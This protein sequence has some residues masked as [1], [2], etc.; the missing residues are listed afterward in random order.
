MANNEEKEKEEKK[1]EKEKP[2]LDKLTE[3]LDPDKI[4]EKVELPHIR[5]HHKYKLEKISITDYADFRQQIIKYMQHHHK[6]IFKTD[7]PDEIAFTKALEI[8]KEFKDE[9][10]NKGFIAAYQSARKGRLGDVIKALAVAEEKEHSASYIHNIFH[11]IDP[12]DWDAHVDLVRQYKS[13]YGSLMP[14]ELKQ[15]SDEELAKDYNSLIKHHIGIVE[16]AKT[17]IKKYE[18]KK[19]KEELEPAA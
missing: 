15:K 5:A 8:L 13:K 6:E 7:M 3:E 16:G 19:K 2:D 1:E 12:L 4:N 14:K 9:A 11:Q 10:G 18:P 17:Y